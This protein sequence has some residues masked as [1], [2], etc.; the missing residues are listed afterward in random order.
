VDV[1]ILVSFSFLI[2][3]IVRQQREIGVL[4]GMLPICS[5]CKRI[6]DEVGGWHQLELFITQRSSARF[7]HTFCED[8]GKKYYPGLMD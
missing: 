1:G 5:H 2:N 8:C 6:R 3:E 4:H 7:S